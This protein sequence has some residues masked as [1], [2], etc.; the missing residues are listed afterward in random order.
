[1]NL[2]KYKEY[3]EGVVTGK[4]VA[5]KYIK[6][7]CERYLS[8]FSKYE[9]RPEK[10][11]RVIRFI[12][13]LKHFT[14]QHSGKPFELLPYQKW[15]IYNIFGFYHKG[16]D[17]RVVRYVY[18]ELA[19]KSGK[20]ALAAAISLYMLI[21]DGE[22]GAE[23]ELVANSRQQAKIAYDM[24]SHFLST[25]DRKGKY[26]ERYRD[27]IKFDKTKSFL[28]V[29]SSDAG[30]NDGYN[31]SCFILDEAHEQPDSK[32]WDV[33]V[34]SQ[35]MR[36]NPLGIIITTAGFNL[37]G[38]CHKYRDTCTEI[39][40]G[41]K[42]NDSQFAAIYTIDEGDKWDDPEIWVKANPSLGITVSKEY[43]ETQVKMAKN[44][45]SLEVGIRTKNLNCWVSSSAVWVS[46]DYL[47]QASKKLEIKDFKDDLCFCGVDLASVSD[48]T[49]VSFCFPKE[50]KFY[51][52]TYYYLPASC[53][54]DNPNSILYQDWARTG[55]LTITPGNVTD[56]D[57]ILKDMKKAAS[58]GV[59]IQQV[60]YDS[61][62]ATQ[63]AINATNEGLPLK[64]FSQALW[65]FNKPTKYFELLIKKGLVVLDDNEITRYCFR[66]VA[67]KYDHNDNVKP[68]KG[69]SDMQK[70]DGVISI[71]ES[72]GVYLDTP[73]FSNEL[74]TL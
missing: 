16:T 51:F 37:F 54:K 28:Q 71:V 72:L 42:E 64:P 20:T 66:N 55:Q 61:Y 13:N 27:K 23:C 58:A 15:I 8:W 60:G 21:G 12:K 74:F 7:A 67:L 22:A 34:S 41:V 11:D 26:F 56:Y 49:A 17:K 24:A 30:G 45:T 29:L 59:L 36:Q 43:L 46:D 48:L 69:G 32:L 63:W 31:S 44:N 73:Q 19:R 70:I 52:K 5:C 9:F 3:A 14:G 6:Q 57:Y 40:A 4:I 50:G 35:G 18:L 1:M 39:L 38:F 68:V 62:N 10:A 33:M 25:I 53:L 65:N 47:L 2:E